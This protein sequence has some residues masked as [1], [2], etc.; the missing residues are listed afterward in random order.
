MGG[1]TSMYSRQVQPLP[2]DPCRHCRQHRLCSRRK[3]VS[4]DART[5]FARSGGRIYPSDHRARMERSHA[6]VASDR[7]ALSPTVRPPAARQRPLRDAENFGGEVSM[8]PIPR[9][10]TAKS[11]LLMQSSRQFGYELM[12]FWL[13]PGS[14]SAGANVSQR[15]G[16]ERELGDVIS[17]CRFG[18]KEQIVFAG[19]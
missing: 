18:Y 12:P 15:A 16:R 17:T 14:C 19:G 9:H 13:R 4:R 11:R 1:T 6:R 7:L 3:T 2:R 5:S 10:A 8:S